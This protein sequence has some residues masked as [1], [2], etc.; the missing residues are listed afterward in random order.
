MAGLSHPAAEVQLLFHTRMAERQIS[1]F[2]LNGLQ[3][4]HLEIQ[5]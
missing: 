5:N 2:T 4:Q 3:M 1:R